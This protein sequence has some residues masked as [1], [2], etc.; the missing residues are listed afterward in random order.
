MPKQITELDWEQS[1]QILKEK[2]EL[3]SETNLSKREID[4][5]LV[6]TKHP[7][8]YNLKQVAEKLDLSPNSVYTHHRNLKA[9][10]I[11]A[12]NTI[13]LVELN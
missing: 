11:K 7:E 8:V 13:E 12:R 4:I 5:Y 9:K 2:Q 3:R 10:K 1:E 6:Y